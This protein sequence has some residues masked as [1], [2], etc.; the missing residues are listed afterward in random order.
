[1]EVRKH[2][3]GHWLVHYLDC[4]NGFMDI[5]RY[6]SLSNCVLNTCSLFYVNYTSLKLEKTNRMLHNLSRT[7]QT[8][9]YFYRLTSETWVLTQQALQQNTGGRR[10]S[11]AGRK[12]DGVKRKMHTHFGFLR[13]LAP[14]PDLQ[15]NFRRNWSP[16]CGLWI[17]SC[18][19]GSAVLFVS[20]VEM[21]AALAC[22]PP[23]RSQL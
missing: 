8:E 18:P 10:H 22:S 11:L 3:W 17:L 1:M 5:L 20:G 14:P 23:I 7:T 9:Q 4:D 19:G 2:F 6:P 15:T 21:L 16:N 13:I 12:G